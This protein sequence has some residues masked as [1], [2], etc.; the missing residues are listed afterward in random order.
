MQLGTA[1]RPV[2]PKDLARKTLVL[3]TLDSDPNPN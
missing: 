3:G 1:V 2:L